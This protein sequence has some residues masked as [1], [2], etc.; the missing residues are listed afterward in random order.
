MRTIPI[1][2]LKKNL[3][4]VYQQYTSLYAEKGYTMDVFLHIEEEDEKVI[5]K[6]TKYYECII[7][8]GFSIYILMNRILDYTQ[9]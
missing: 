4:Q 9:K 8:N 5:L 7:E 6:N 1:K 3:T 2:V